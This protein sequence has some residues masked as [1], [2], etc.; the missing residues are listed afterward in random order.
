MS[1]AAKTGKG[2]L[3]RIGDGLAAALIRLDLPPLSSHLLTVRGRRSGRQLTTPV[4]VVMDGNQR[5]LVSMYGETDW[6]QNARASGRVI[7]TRG[8]RSREYEVVEVP[9]G[10]RVSVLRSYLKIEPMG[11]RQ[12]SLD[13]DA[14]EEDLRRALRTSRYCARKRGLTRMILAA[15]PNR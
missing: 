13:P 12:L 14:A 3:S 5:W 7:L 4:S 15:R 1:A 9:P 8:R 2:L 11:R 6:V 10:E